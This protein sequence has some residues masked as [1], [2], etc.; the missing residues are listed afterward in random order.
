MIIYIQNYFLKL[1]ASSH[2]VNKQGFSLIKLDGR[3]LLKFLNVIM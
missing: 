3:G 2:L 1:R